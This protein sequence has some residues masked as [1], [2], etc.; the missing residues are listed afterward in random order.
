MID[1]Y[2][3]AV[4]PVR[5]LE[6]V[7]AAA[8]MARLADLDLSDLPTAAAAQ[9]AARAGERE[10]Y[11]ADRRFDQWAAEYLNRNQDRQIEERAAMH[12]RYA[13][14]LAD[15][16]EVLA[17][18]YWTAELRAA[19][20]RLQERTEQAGLLRRVTGAAAKDR[21]ELDAR[22][23]QLADVEQ[24]TAEQVGAITTER[25]LALADLA[26]RHTR[27]NALA[28]EHL[29]ER[30]PTF[31]AEERGPEATPSGRSRDGQGGRERVYYRAW[32]IA[33]ASS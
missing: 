13:K 14:D 11:H 25:V 20:E 3:K 19:V 5:Q 4:N 21:A 23:R 6:G 16:K 24:R 9:K 1:W 32:P 27:E 10:R 18:Q 31:Y 17:K 26:D 30:R 28:R 12:A 22:R 15:R 7:R 29:A 2:G 8:F 33:P